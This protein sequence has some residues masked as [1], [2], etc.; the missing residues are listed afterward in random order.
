MPEEEG[1]SEKIMK[2]ANYLVIGGFLIYII[3]KFKPGPTPPTPPTPPKEG[4]EITKIE[5]D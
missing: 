5:V 2:I 3:S 4:V 1:I